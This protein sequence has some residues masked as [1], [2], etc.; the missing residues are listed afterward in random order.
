MFGRLKGKDKIETVEN[1]FILLLFL[2]GA[3]LSFGIGSTIITPRGWP[4][5][6]AMVGSLVC[7][8]FTLA[9]LILWLIKDLKGE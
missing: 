1:I 9:L 7:F 6:L 2:S 4:V 5:V 3:I 8:V